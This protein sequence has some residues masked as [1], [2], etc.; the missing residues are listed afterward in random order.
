M[1]KSVVGLENIEVRQ[2]PEGQGVSVTRE[3]K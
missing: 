3:I 2:F 1:L